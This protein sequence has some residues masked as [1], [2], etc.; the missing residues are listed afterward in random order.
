MTTGGGH[1]LYIFLDNDLNTENKS[2]LALCLT[3]TLKERKKEGKR[4][5]KEGHPYTSVV[6]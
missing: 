6:S 3:T 1:V 5:R 4:G 2:V